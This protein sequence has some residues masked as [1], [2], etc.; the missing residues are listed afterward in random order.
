[1]PHIFDALTNRHP[2]YIAS[3]Q[4][5]VSSPGAGLSVPE[6]RVKPYFIVASVE[7]GN[8]TTKCVLT[9]TCMESGQ[10][11]I[12]NKVVVNTREAR[13]PRDGEETIAT[14][15]V[16]HP[17]S[18]EAVAELARDV[19]ERCHREAGLSVQ[20]DLD[21]LVRSTG[22]NASW[23]SP[24][25][26]AGFIGAIADGCLQAGVSARK[27]TPPLDKNHLPAKLQAFSLMDKITL[28]DTVAG[29]IPPSGLVSE[30]RI[31]A[32]EMEGVLA[33]AG[34]KD[35]A[36][37]SDVDYRNPCMAMDFGT[38]VDGCIT[39]TVEP[40]AP[41]PFART[42]GSICGLGGAIA[43]GLA[44]GS[45]EVDNTMGTARDLLGDAH[46]PPLLAGS[47][48]STVKGFTDRI[49]DIISIDVVPHNRT[50]CG[51]VPVDPVLAA[52]Q[53]ITI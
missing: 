44:R 6:Y 34:I 47:E 46:V 25:E 19:L 53:G 13:Q 12:L 41:D 11:Y 35:G 20:E 24:R 29:V 15:L 43:D 17:V 10:T 3:L 22:M 39:G 16:G 5:P 32:N 21:F 23:H 37:A 48:R 4:V 38:T 7:M 28:R 8:T 50:T 51:G 26:V 36:L 1:M 52:G 9:G 27:M 30:D 14:T 2:C 18:R 45:P 42:T 31:V 49:H 33:M 40:D